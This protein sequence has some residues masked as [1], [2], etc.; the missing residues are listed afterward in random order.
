MLRFEG[1]ILRRG[2]TI[3]NV[4]YVNYSH[5]AADIDEALDRMGEALRAM[6][7]AGL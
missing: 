1:E 6:K 4:M 2:D 3:Y 7:V 5:S